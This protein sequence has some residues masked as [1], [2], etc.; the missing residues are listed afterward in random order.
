MEG[1]DS[2]VVHPVADFPGVDGLRPVPVVVAAGVAL[3]AAEVSTA[4]PL[5]V[6][7]VADALVAV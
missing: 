6:L 5:S 1:A 4:G 7:P 3:R 2:G